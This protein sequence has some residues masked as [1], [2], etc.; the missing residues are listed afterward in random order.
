MATSSST[1]SSALALLPLP[2]VAAL[3]TP[4]VRGASCVWCS[5]TFGPGGPAVDLGPRVLKHL[6]ARTQ[7]FPRACRPCVAKAALTALHAHAPLCEQC[8]DEA[9]HCDTGR[10]LTRLIREYRR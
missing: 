3:S 9:G 6:D 4:Q 7:W 1:D 2:R 5:A 8:T 10:S